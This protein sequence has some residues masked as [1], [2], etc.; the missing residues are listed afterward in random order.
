VIVVDDGSRDGSAALAEAAGV[1]VVRLAGGAGPG[2]ARNAGAAA[3][4]DPGASLAFTDADCY[5]APG[6]LAAGLRA[7]EHADLV[8]GRVA[9]DP[10][11]PP[12]GPCD[13][14]VSVS[15]ESGLYE[16]ANLFVSRAAFDRAGGFGDGTAAR[17]KHLG[18]D[19]A[20]GWAV[21]RAGGRTAFCAEALV[22]HHVFRRD[23]RSYLT[24][25]VRRRHFPALVREIPELREAFLWKRTFLTRR[26]AAFDLALAGV[27]V[28]ATRRSPLPLLAALPYARLVRRGAPVAVAADVVGAAALLAGSLAARRPVL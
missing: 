27:A 22:H 7:L 10:S 2:A 8:Q 18:E 1:R 16:T 3:A 20:F 21:R 11:V 13:R 28:A 4:A 15:R 25:Q 17:G 6:W 23:A 12:P 9:P 19:V 5:P 26:G 14:S 24:E